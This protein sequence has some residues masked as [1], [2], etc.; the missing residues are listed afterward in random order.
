MSAAAA[1]DEKRRGDEMGSVLALLC[2]WYWAD[3]PTRLVRPSSV[4]CADA[5]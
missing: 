3:G 4:R 2:G 1:R 5:D